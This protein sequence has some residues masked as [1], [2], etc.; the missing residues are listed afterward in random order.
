M[1]APAIVGDR[2]GAELELFCSSDSFHSVGELDGGSGLGDP[3]LC[4]S[5]S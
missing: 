5:V 1:G 3:E 2:D 4:S